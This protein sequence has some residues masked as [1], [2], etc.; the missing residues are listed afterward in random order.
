MASDEP[1]S[2]L[3]G[4]LQTESARIW[5][6]SQ[7]K[8]FVQEVL[9]SRVRQKPDTTRPE[10]RV[11]SV[12]LLR[13]PVLLFLDASVDLLRVEPVVGERRSDLPSV[14]HS[15]EPEPLRFSPTFLKVAMTSHTSNPVPAMEALRPT[16]PSMN[17]IPGT[18]RILTASRSGTEA[19]LGERRPPSPHLAL[20]FLL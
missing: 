16:G 9:Q 18:R 8:V 7:R 20:Y 5:P 15:Y 13:R 19:N 10:I 12:Q 14:S 3:A 2:M 17:T 6:P 11:L 1:N 4:S